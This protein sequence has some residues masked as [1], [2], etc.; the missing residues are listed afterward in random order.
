MRQ[1]RLVYDCPASGAHNMAVD[2][3]LLM[4]NNGVPVLRFYGWQP[5][6]LSLGYGQRVRDVDFERLAALGWEAVRRPTGGSAVL[7]I[8]ELTYSLILPSSHPLAAGSVV[9]SYRRISSALMLG[10]QKL[11]LRPQALPADQPAA[12]G[13]V[14]FETPSHYEITVQGRKLI[15]SAQTRRK[16][17]VLQH[18]SLPLFGD[19]ARICDALVFASERQRE[20]ARVRVR[21]HA[22]TLSEALKMSSLEWREAAAALVEGFREA[23]DIEFEESAL[24]SLEVEFADRLADEKF[25][26][27]RLL[28]RR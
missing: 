8:D 28:N 11:N 4:L 5:P 19:I 23:F 10:L 24:T 22:M 3:A 27:S 2:E 18:G 21:A 15:G 25:R 26:D 13:V 14:C 6:C 9:D 1:W 17:G 20:L 7:H 12:T 16:V